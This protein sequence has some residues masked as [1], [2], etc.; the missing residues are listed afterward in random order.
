MG[1]KILKFI[2]YV[3]M[4][5]AFYG[6]IMAYANKEIMQ[7]VPD[8]ASM[9]E[10]PLFQLLAFHGFLFLTGIAVVIYAG[11]KEKKDRKA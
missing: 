8:V 2:G 4:G 6:G 5:S 3:L 1:N 9:G 11:K 10:Y 7:Q